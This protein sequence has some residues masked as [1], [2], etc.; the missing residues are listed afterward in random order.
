VKIG[1]IAMSG[2][3]ADDPELM[4][5]GLTMPGIME[6]GE[7]IASLPSLSLLTLAALTPPD[8]EVEYREVRDL[9]EGG[10]L[11]MDYDLVAITSLSAQVLEAYAL[12][13]RYRAA[14]VKVVMGGLHVTVMP[15]E[16]L[17]YCDAVVVGEAELV[18]PRVV[19]DFRRGGLQRVYRA[20]GEFDLAEAPI[21]RYELLEIAKYNRLPVQTSRGCPHRCD[22]CASS[23]LLTKKYKVK[24][25]EK[26]VAEVRRIKELWRH[27][28]I[29]FADD[30][31]FVMRGHY[32][33]L[34]RALKG[35]RI[36]W[37][38]ECDVSVADDAELLDLMHES[39]CR[40][41]LIGLES[42]TPA[43]LSGIEMR[44]N[45][46]LRQ[47]PKYEAAV[48]RIQARG[49]AVN[50]CF[51][52]GLDGDTPETFDEVYRFVERTNLFDVQITV[53]TPFPGT[54]L[55]ARL[56]A[57]G[58]I[59]RPGAWNKCTLFDVNFVPRH[60]TPEALQRGLLD[61][62][63]RLYDPAFLRARREGF[64]EEC[65]RHRVQPL[66]RLDGTGVELAEA[67]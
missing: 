36:R 48:R 22:F 64:M 56:L 9:A 19:E 31:S 59:L 12:A 23:I 50:G 34:L 60:M 39:G 43:G 1:M 53:L 32:K 47:L 49:I 62:A 38:T 14:G 25:V 55:Y 51:V 3:R 10:A 7:V 26:V 44:A 58:R 11:P 37:F 27:P 52:L 5:A 66:M 54:P 57:E 15:E 63:Q 42:P 46:K 33:Q 41:V 18:W 2:V 24:P 16:A 29:E 35:E 6:R 61:L 4:R 28:F 30:N 67:S 20:E 17:G 45:W 8:V 21:P 40:E 65:R 13:A